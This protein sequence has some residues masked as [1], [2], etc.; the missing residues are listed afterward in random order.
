MPENGNRDH[1]G[2]GVYVH[3]TGYSYEI[4]VNNHRNPP[5]VHLDNS[6]IDALNRFRKRMEEKHKR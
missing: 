5:V 4:S 1:L 3:F 2:D 6:I